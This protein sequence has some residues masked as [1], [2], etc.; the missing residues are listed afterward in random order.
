MEAE[1]GVTQSI[2]NELCSS[3]IQLDPNE[4]EKGVTRSMSDELHSLDI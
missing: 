4:S 3:D 1:K 2:I